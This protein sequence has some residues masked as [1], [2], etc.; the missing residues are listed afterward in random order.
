MDPQTEC[1]VSLKTAPRPAFCAAAAAAAA[2]VV[3]FIFASGNAYYL[4]RDQ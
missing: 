2:A 4:V 1:C 3:A